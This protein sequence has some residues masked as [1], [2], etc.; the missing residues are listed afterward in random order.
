MPSSLATLTHRRCRSAQLD[1]LSRADLFYR[2]VKN[3]VKIGEGD[4]T[5]PT[6]SLGAM[7]VEGWKRRR[8]N[9]AGIK[10]V[11]YEASPGRLI[12]PS[13]LLTL[14]SFSQMAHKPE[15][16]DIRGGATTS[17]HIDIL[18]SSALNEIVLRVA[19]GDADAIDDHFVSVS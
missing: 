15:Q 10:V 9:P 1:L 4:G 7:C 18:G 17:D 6:L 16:M 11:T 19:A 12:H 3:G 8:W 14:N 5:V 2:Q 13:R